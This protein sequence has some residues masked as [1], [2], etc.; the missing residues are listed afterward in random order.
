M[1]PKKLN[2]YGCISARQVRPLNHY[3]PSGIKLLP[4]PPQADYSMFTIINLPI[5]YF[6]EY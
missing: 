3:L 5:V 2:N 4:P 1:F 6:Q